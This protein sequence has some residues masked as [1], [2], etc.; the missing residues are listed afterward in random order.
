MVG[1]RFR[2]HSRHRVHIFIRFKDAR[3]LYVVPV[4]EVILNLITIVE[5]TRGSSKDRIDNILIS[6][7]VREK[8][9]LVH[10]C[11]IHGRNITWRD[12][13]RLDSLFLI[14]LHC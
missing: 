1:E 4:E 3:V 13:E 12:R 6:M 5:L 9:T 10:R 7:A 14:L 2:E 11:L 8:A